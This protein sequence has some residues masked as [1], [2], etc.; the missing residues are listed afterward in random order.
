MRLSREKVIRL[1]H[2]VVDQLV[3]SDDVEFI[4]DR[5]SIRQKIIA[6]INGFL[7]E[8]EKMDTD[9]RKKISSQKK[10]IPEGSAEWDI[11]YR[12][13]YAEEM[14]RLGVTAER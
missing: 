2:V 11:L 6:L 9:V 10:E 13:Y 7:Q 3:A 1:S 14:K 8:E 5:E 4:E 12:K